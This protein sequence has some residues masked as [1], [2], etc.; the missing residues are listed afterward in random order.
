MFLYS[1]LAMAAVNL[2]PF[3]LLI[4]LD[5]ETWWQWIWRGLGFLFV[6][7]AVPVT[8]VQAGTPVHGQRIMKLDHHSCQSYQWLDEDWKCVPWEQAG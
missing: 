6:I 5:S 7:V 8:I 3:W 4:F 1:V 2:I